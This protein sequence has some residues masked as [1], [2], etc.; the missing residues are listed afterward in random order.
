MTISNK[1]LTPS[2]AGSIC[3]ADIDGELSVLEL[4]K[5]MRT[6]KHRSH[7][8]LEGLGPARQP[9]ASEQTV[10]TMLL[11]RASEEQDWPGDD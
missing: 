11:F 4:I 3:K 10:N 8:Q 9:Q 6:I 7:P 2:S 1:P 5:G